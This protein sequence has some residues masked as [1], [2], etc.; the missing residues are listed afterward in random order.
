[1]LVL[2]MG[3]LSKTDHFEGGYCRAALSLL[4]RRKKRA[5]AP[6]RQRIGLTKV[7]TCARNKNHIR[8]I[9][10]AEDNNRSSLL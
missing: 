1:M 6:N 8:P 4:K 10:R 3:M 7:S 5:L 9:F 2:N